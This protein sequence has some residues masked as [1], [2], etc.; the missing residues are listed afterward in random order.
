MKVNFKLFGFAVMVVVTFVSSA[1]IY[2][3]GAPGMPY[4]CEVWRDGCNL[5][6]DKPSTD[7]GA[8]IKAYII[9]YKDVKSS[10][11][12][13][14]G[15]SQRCRFRAAYMKEGTSGEFRVKAENKVGVGEP[16]VPSAIVTFRNPY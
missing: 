13:I 15:T 4:I 16:S 12:C 11:W 10:E 2:P 3:P 6:F 8:A 9:E 14:R 7:G 1:P 5:K